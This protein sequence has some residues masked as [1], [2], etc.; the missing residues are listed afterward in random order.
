MGAKSGLERIKQKVAGIGQDVNGWRVA[1]RF[2]D[3]AT[4]KGDWL[5]RAALAGTWRTPAVQRSK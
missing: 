2:G 5:Q 4:Y 1:T 3:R